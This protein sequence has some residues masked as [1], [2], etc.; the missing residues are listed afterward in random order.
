VV[1]SYTQEPVDEEAG[2]V[3]AKLIFSLEA[4]RDAS[5]EEAHRLLRRSAAQLYAPATAFLRAAGDDAHALQRQLGALPAELEHMMRTNSVI[6]SLIWRL[7]RAIREAPRAH[8]AEAQAV[9]AASWRSFAAESGSNAF[10]LPMRGSLRGIAPRVQCAHCGR[11]DLPSKKCARCL[12][13][14]YCS[15]A[16][17]AQAWGAHKRAC[18]A[19]AAALASGAAPTGP[20]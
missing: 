15:A 19:A 2:G 1:A 20:G 8:R 6:D 10:A 12:A 7:P 4:L 3:L 16:C 5:V 13:A 17:Q 18:R 11:P 9:F 14:S